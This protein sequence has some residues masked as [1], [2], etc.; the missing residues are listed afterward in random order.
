MSDFG[1]AKDAEIF[2]IPV[3]INFWLFGVLGFR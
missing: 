3:V 2:G 1:T